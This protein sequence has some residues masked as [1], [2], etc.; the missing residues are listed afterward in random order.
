VSLIGRDVDPDSQTVLVRAE[1][2]E[3]SACLR[4]GQYV[5]VRLQLGGTDKLYRVP[6]NAVVHTK[7]MTLIFVRAPYGFVATQIQVAGQE[8]DYTVVTGKLSGDES[9]AVSGL[10]AIKAA[11]MGLGGHAE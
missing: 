4:P 11:W 3:A 7:E 8:S 9:V 6:T 1:A 10:A 5:Q 2:R